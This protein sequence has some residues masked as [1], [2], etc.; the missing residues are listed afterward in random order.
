MAKA[1]HKGQGHSSKGE[2]LR[3]KS[4][5]AEAKAIGA[6]NEYLL[7]LAMANE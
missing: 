7:S 1:D 2:K 5:T 6:R 3:E 4:A